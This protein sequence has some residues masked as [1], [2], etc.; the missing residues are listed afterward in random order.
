MTFDCAPGESARSG[1]VFTATMPAMDAAISDIL[2][3]LKRL[4]TSR[5]RDTFGSEAHG[6]DLNPPLAESTVADFESRHRIHL[7]ADYHSFLIHAGNGGAGPSYGVF[8][9]GEMDSNWDF[10]RWR[11]D[12]GFIGNLSA[13]FPHT[14]PWND[15]TGQPE[16]NE[17][18]ESDPA[19]EDEYTRQMETFDQH[20]WNPANVNGAV[21]ICHLG[22]A[23]RQW[24][25]ISGPE[26]GHIWCDDRA[27]YKGLYPLQLPGLDRVTFLEWYNNWL[28]EAL[29]H[30]DSKRTP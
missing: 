4:R 22:C 24:L 29:A 20:Y 28:A 5:R 14:A 3:A 30:L 1:P 6:F 11:E 9:L 19:W 27:D 18:R 23:Y 12:D 2:A 13:P 26:A 16:Y 15:L 8:K 17:S 7:P 10:A 25:V 21:P